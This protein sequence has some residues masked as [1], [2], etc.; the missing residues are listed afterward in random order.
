MLPEGRAKRPYLGDF[1]LAVLV[2]S[3]LEN[4][5]LIKRITV[6]LSMT[7]IFRGHPYLTPVW[8]NLLF[9]VALLMPIRKEA[10]CFWDLSWLVWLCIFVI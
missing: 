4:Q 2:S 9:L 5:N 7:K 8:M 6:D 3:K 1:V 10:G